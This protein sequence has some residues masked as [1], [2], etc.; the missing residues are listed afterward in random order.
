VRGGQAPPVL[1]Q[2]FPRLRDSG[3]QRMSSPGS[4]PL[5]DLLAEADWLTRLS[6][7]LV[8]DED[9][10]SDLVQ[11]TWVAALRSPP[12]ASRPP[13][14]WLAEVMRNALR[15]RR[16]DHERRS[17]REERAGQGEPVA[18]PATDELLERMRLQ[19]I[20]AERV[21]ALDE[22]F[23]TALLMRY[24]E[25]RSSADIARALAVPEGTVRWRLKEARDRLRTALDGLHGGER[26]AWAVGLAPA[27]MAGLKGGLLVGMTKT[28]A[29]AVTV[30]VVLAGALAFWYM[31]DGSEHG[32]RTLSTY[33]PPESGRG[34]LRVFGASERPQ[35]TS[36]SGRVVTPDGAAAFGSVVTATLAPAGEAASRARPPERPHAQARAGADGTFR[37]DNLPPGSYR[38]VATAEGFAPA[39]S[40]PIAV[41]S[42]G[43]RDVLLEL[44]RGGFVLSGIVQDSGGGPISGAQ[45]LVRSREAIG[46]T[47]TND[48]GSYGV[49]LE[50]GPYTL[51]ASADGYAPARSSVE[52]PGETRRD[53][54]LHPGAHVGG[55]VVRKDG[56][57][58]IAGALVR[59][60]PDG[61]GGRGDETTTVSDGGFTLSGV[62][63]GTYTL[64]AANGRLVGFAP[65]PV[66]V[67]VAENLQGI[68]VALEPAFVI[69]GTVRDAAGRAVAAAAI[70]ME[71]ATKMVD[72]GSL[73]GTVVASTD[74]E[75]RYLV[76]GVL[77]G[78]FRLK[79]GAA[80]HAPSRS[81]V[82]Q[83]K[84]A[85]ATGIDLALPR[86]GAV[87]G[88][89]L[90]SEGRPT[91]NA[92]VSVTV[93]EVEAVDALWR[94]SG[95]A[96][97]GADGLFRVDALG[98]GSVRITA[99]HERHGSVAVGP[100]PLGEGEVKELVV[101]FSKPATL[102][103]TVRW[104]DGSPA[105]GA[106]VRWTAFGRGG[107][108]AALAQVGADGGFRLGPLGEGKGF[109][110]AE[111]SHTTWA[112]I[113]GAAAAHKQDVLLA[114]GEDK[115]GIALVLPKPDR[116]ITG[117]VLGPDG[118][119]LA[120]A[121]VG[122]E[123]PVA[124][125][126][127]LRLNERRRHSEKS[128]ATTSADG[129]FTLEGLQ[130]RPYT[131]FA[132][133]PRYPVAEL[134]DVQGGARDVRLK[135]Q[136]G[137]TL[138]GVVLSADR[139]PVAQYSLALLPAEHPGKVGWGS[140]LFVG[141]QQTVRQPE[142]IFTVSALHAGEYDVVVTTPDGRAGRIGG[143]RLQD[144]EERKDLRI[145][146]GPSVTLRGRVVAADTGQGIADVGIGISGTDEHV[147][148]RTD[149]SGSFTLER[150][151]PGRTLALNVRSID[152][153]TYFPERREVTLPQDGK[154]TFEVPPFHLLRVNTDR[155]FGPAS[156]GLRTS[157]RE[158]DATVS[159]VVP[160]SPAARAA[161][162]VGDKL[163]TI[164]G[165]EVRLLGSHA[166]GFLLSG[167]PGSPV[168][169][170][171]S[172]RS[173]QRTLRLTRTQEP[174]PR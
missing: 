30:A 117:V 108:G 83:I 26:N 73:A 72:M 167:D 17:R 64:S 121:V 149:A 27:P 85:D 136:A 105:V 109:V 60:E 21:V 147:H 51:L 128:P 168:E 49:T 90:D 112:R 38:L 91:E 61:R 163:V 107:G 36:V 35:G 118:S 41:A 69:G 68:V 165:R 173:G 99:T 103:G 111:L 133:H 84:D 150:Q 152:N 48:K 76:E 92:S 50:R 129:T 6:H 18:S 42:R 70:R 13:R 34:T 80:P 46:V 29:G 15:R 89:V 37:L 62:A 57:Q 119:P 47:L 171:I 25:G 1:S 9:V 151:T 97:S 75:G 145:T 22:P 123:H 77:P 140:G 174:A 31:R 95:N 131:V 155:G 154:A 55:R 59:L 158:P 3:G 162:S 65:E 43:P 24:Y 88:K 53:F 153:R 98:A 138:S 139:L 164:D 54:T 146:V 10:A 56:G 94:G 157:L 101:R 78:S 8:S 159:E 79:A 124:S 169:V 71:D 142:G 4:T 58:G 81:R 137:A 16:R 11:D 52:L 106:R 144:G 134:R 127:S 161:I 33:L 67:G 87:H 110:Q 7:H 166:I 14:P 82:V 141:R 40:E 45:V 74:S 39:R 66:R 28:S 44:G 32:G 12:D 113:G 100:E 143:L 102:S 148:A 122:A 125:S 126:A 5:D 170:T 19:K 23:R 172:G 130:K 86:G 104:D 120:D 156:V 132:V 160:S 2:R 63:P 96:K 20:V 114:A 116:V 115:T 135:V 93:R